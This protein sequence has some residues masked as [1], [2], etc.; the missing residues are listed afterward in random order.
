MRHFLTTLP[1][2]IVLAACQPANL[3]PAP[4]SDDMSR[5][6]IL[7]A[8]EARQLG[9]PQQA[10]EIMRS[11]FAQKPG[12]PQVILNLG[13]ALIANNASEDAVNLYDALI[14]MRP[15]DPLGY[16]GKG[17]AF[18]HSGNHMAA[19]ELYEKALLL[20]PDS[21]AIQNNLAMSFILSEEPQKAIEI[22]APLEKTAQSTATIRQNLA[23]AYGIVGDN[24]NARA[25]NLK[26]LNEE[27][28][29][30]NLK[31]YAHYK[32]LLAE[33]KADALTTRALY[34]PLPGDDE[35]PSAA[36]KESP[37]QKAKSVKEKPKKII[38]KPAKTP[39]PKANDNPPVPSGYKPSTSA[40]YAK[41]NT[42]E[43][44][45]EEST[46]FWGYPAEPSY[47]SSEKR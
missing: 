10:L 8:R 24:R 5:A 25:I 20:S 22:L 11:I 15:Q 16:N 45:K 14:A 6:A 7:Q 4:V 28:T 33:H 12:D 1:L 17:V 18:D 41:E 27:Q 19:K 42:S 13:Y 37:A 35:T 43:T 47:P 44:P 9:Q 21:P 31:F 46:S 29:E 30:D 26:D 3:S 40:E 23:L 36:P 2:F 32:K 34:E 39:A 38:D